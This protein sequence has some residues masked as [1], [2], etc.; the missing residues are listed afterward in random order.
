M[1]GAFYQLNSHFKR[2][3]ILDYHH[4]KENEQ[5]SENEGSIVLASD[6]AAIFNVANTTLL[7]PFRFPS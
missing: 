1:F 7:L 4:S 3:T 5:P 6:P 2:V